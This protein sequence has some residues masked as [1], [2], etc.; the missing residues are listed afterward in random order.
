[1]VEV[2][3]G[4]RERST[5]RNNGAIVQFREAATFE[6]TVFGRVDKEGGGLCMERR[7]YW[8]GHYFIEY[9]ITIRKKRGGNE[10][11]L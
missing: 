11:N 8:F 5:R 3:P 1:M 6:N 7:W 2:V 10:L 4:R 9:R